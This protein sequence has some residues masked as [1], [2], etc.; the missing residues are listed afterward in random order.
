[1]GILT[2]ILSFFFLILITIKSFNFIKNMFGQH[3][4]IA[5]IELIKTNIISLLYLILFDDVVGLWLDYTFLQR[6]EVMKA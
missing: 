6:S 2:V 3:F 1:M 4:N 5:F